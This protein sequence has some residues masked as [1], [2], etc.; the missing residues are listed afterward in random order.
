MLP[1]KL[2]PLMTKKSQSRLN[3][4]NVANTTS[5]LCD[6]TNSLYHHV[7]AIH[8]GIKDRKCFQC[9]FATSRVSTLNA[10]GKAV[11]MKTNQRP[12]RHKSVQV[13]LSS[14]N[15]KKLSTKIRGRG[16]QSIIWESNASWIVNWDELSF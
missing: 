4:C 14:F 3:I 8:M 16:N 5:R 9:Y 2:I 10:H 11:H 12:P 15:K 6:P 13:P 1:F 7:K